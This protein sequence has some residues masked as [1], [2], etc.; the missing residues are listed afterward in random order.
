M[1]CRPCLLSVVLVACLACAARADAPKPVGFR[2][3]V[4]PILVRKCLGCHNDRKASG[5]L[6]MSTFALLKKGGK[7][8]AETILE[9]GD[10]DASELVASVRPDASPRMPYK[11]P[12]LSAAEISVLER[13]VK[14]G[15]RFD[16]KSESGTTLASLVDPLQMLPRVKPRPGTTD[17]VTAL[18]FSRDGA[19]LAAAVGRSVTLMNAADASPRPLTAESP[20]PVTSLSFTPDGARLV[21]SGGR[22]GQFGAVQVFEASSGKVLADVRGHSDAILSAALAPDGKTLATSSYDR[23]VVLWD[24]MSGKEVRT[25]SDHTDAVYTVA[26]TPDGKTL[27]SAGAD[28]T[29]KLWE[30]ATGKKLRTFS[31]ATAELYAVAFTADGRFVLAAGVDRSIRA[32]DVAAPDAPVRSVFAHDGPVIRMAVSPDGKTLATSGEDRDVKLWTLPELQPRSAMEDQPDWPQA[33]AFRPDGAALAVGRQDGSVALFD[34]A[35]GKLVRTLRPA[36]GRTSAPKP[37]LTRN[38]S[39]NPPSP[40]GVA[41]GKTTRVTLTGLGVGKATAVILPEPGVRAALVSSPKPSGDRAEVDLEV[42]ADAR[43]G[44]HRIGVVGP[45]G[46]PAFQTFAV[47]A[48]PEAAEAEPN[49]RLAGVKSVTVP[50]TLTGTIEK[51]GDVDSFRVKLPAG[52]PVIARVAARSLGSTLLARVAFKD[53][54]GRILAE[55]TVEEG[56]KDPILT[57]TPAHDETVIVEVADVDFGGSAAHFYRVEFGPTA[58]V[59]LVFPLGAEVGRSTKVGV[60]GFNL[61]GG[62][63]ASVNVDAKAAPG[64]LVEIPVHGSGSA[65]VAGNRS[66]VVAEGPQGVEAEPND[67][68]ARASS[69]ATPGGASGRIGTIGDVD[70]FRFH[71]RKGER[72]V[73]EVFGRRLGIPIDPVLEI[74]DASGRP[75]PRAVLRPVAQTEVAFRDHNASSSGIRLT[76]WANL[77]MRD[78]VLIGREVTRVTALPKNPDDDCVFWSEGGQ[79]AG[80]FETTPEHHPM[81]QPIYKVEVHPPGAT[82]PAGGVAPVTLYYRNDDGGAAFQK[83]ARLTFDVPADGD[84]LVRVADVRDL[85]GVDFGYHLVFRR[86]AP[87]FRFTPSTE[88]PNVPRGGTTLVPITLMRLD[89]FDEPVEI[90]AT[91][92]PAGVSSR[93]AVV[94][95]GQSTAILSISADSTAPAY[96]APTWSLTA[97]GC[98]TAAVRRSRWCTRSTP[99]ARPEGS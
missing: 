38:P 34:A 53:E 42:A 86:P 88:N 52:R 74:L 64:S 61:A 20:G 84:Y 90:V 41:R 1:S 71:G 70:H 37:E 2:E 46:V 98:P 57:Y 63:E 93:P 94:E 23:R 30:A 67:D 8:A 55:S 18:A 66:L 13:W 45:L 10:P 44:V 3:N 31:D 39:L 79:R 28:R 82:F 68:P 6:N 27:A 16:G 65:P 48:Y 87:D 11:L 51:P 50:A 14:E 29:V 81:G 58:L 96:S 60:R 35:T 43:V 24:L 7:T 92:L 54:S 69:V 56:T 73:V 9:A 91:G 15:A 36:G 95:R 99:A 77:A 89:G 59:E 72:W 5:G 17:P 47:E 76:Q 26:F 22:P 12:P 75:I 19:I 78:V 83:D 33:I 85:G 49:D 25:L 32:W 97:R 62:G 40:R 80:L 4:A 21:A